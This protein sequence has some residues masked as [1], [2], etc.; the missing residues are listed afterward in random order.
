MA[1]RELRIGMVGYKFMGKAHSHAYRDLPF[2]FDTGVTPVMT[3]IAGRDEAGFALRQNSS[4]S[5]P[6]RRTGAG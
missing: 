5:R 4:D 1:P 6:A 2:F 3:A